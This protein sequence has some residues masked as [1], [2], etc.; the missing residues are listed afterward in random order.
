MA[1][2]INQSDIKQI[3]QPYYQRHNYSQVAREMGISPSTVKKYVQVNYKPVDES[4]IKHIAI[5]DVP[6]T[7]NA[8]IFHRIA[9]I[10]ILC[11][12]DE[13]KEELNYMKEWEIEI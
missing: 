1:T 6:R 9:D 10:D 5:T 8:E 4:K 2:K 12:T 7:F 3:N 13:E 11:L